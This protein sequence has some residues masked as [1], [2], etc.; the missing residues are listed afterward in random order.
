MIQGYHVSLKNY[1]GKVAL[2]TIQKS[3][4]NKIIK[5]GKLA[6]T[7]SVPFL[8]SFLIVSSSLMPVVLTMMSLCEG[9]RDYQIKGCAGSGGFA[10]VFK[11][12]VDSDPNEIVALKVTYFVKNHADFTFYSSK[13]DALTRSVLI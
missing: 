11:A 6:A 7:S 12:F 5:I 8:F 1:P 9:K 2:S 3:S 4:R 13:C 10:Q